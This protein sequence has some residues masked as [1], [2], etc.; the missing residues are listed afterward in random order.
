MV[1]NKVKL[2]HCSVNPPV[3]APAQALAP[4]PAPAPALAP[5][6]AHAPAPAHAPTPASQLNLKSKF[7]I[8]GQEGPRGCGSS[9]AS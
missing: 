1:A 3:C 2:D 7:C 5:N 8:S 6:P 9:A 4:N